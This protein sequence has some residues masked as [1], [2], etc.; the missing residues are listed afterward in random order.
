MF[1]SSDI[2]N[3][4]RKEALSILGP[5]LAMQKAANFQSVFAV[6][7]DPREEVQF[8]QLHQ[9]G[10]MLPFG[11]GTARP[12]TQPFKGGITT[13]KAEQYGDGVEWLLTTEAEARAKAIDLRNLIAS[14]TG[15]V[16]SYNTSRDKLACAVLKNGATGTGY[17]GQPLFS[18]SHPTR[19]HFLDGDNIS[20]VASAAS[21]ISATQ[22]K[23][24]HEQFAETMAIAE[25]GE[26]ID[27]QPTHVLVSRTQDF[28]NMYAV[29][30]SEKLAGVANNDTNESIRSLGIQLQHWPRLKQTTPYLYLVRAN[31]GLKMIDKEALNVD[32]FY[33]PEVRSYYVG[34]VFQSVAGYVDFRC[35]LRRE[36]SA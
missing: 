9:N 32:V 3:Y 22:F 25:N 17:D 31:G 5:T 7:S 30:F 28:H 33:K 14:E 18:A 23:E 26:E 11:R 16:A 10:S 24:D 29:L 20:N 6:S 12:I 8:G 36:I 19:S 35:A 21:A 13:L 1:Q 4:L 34:P 27:N 15:W 2:L